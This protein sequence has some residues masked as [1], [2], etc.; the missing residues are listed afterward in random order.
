MIEITIE[1]NVIGT[2]HAPCPKHANRSAKR[3]PPDTANPSPPH[4]VVGCGVLA[5]KTQIRQWTSESCFLTV[6]RDT[7]MRKPQTGSEEQVSLIDKDLPATRQILHGEI[8]SVRGDCADFEPSRF[9]V[10]GD[11]VTEAA[12]R[13]SGVLIAV[14]P[15]RLEMSPVVHSVHRASTTRTGEGLKAASARRLQ[16]R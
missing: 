10:E 15:A 9:A 11:F 7:A 14:L 8:E 3:A 16:D 1:Q 6:Q 12:S 4:L 5:R 2:Q 13:G